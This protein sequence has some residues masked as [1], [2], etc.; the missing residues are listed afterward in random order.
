MSTGGEVFLLEM[1]EPIRIYDLAQQMIRLSG[2]E[3]GKDI[4][5]QV[6]GLRPGEKLYEELLIDQSKAE[7]TKHPRVFS[8]KEHKLSWDILEEKLEKLLFQ[9]QT[10]NYPELINNLKELVTEYQPANQIVTTTHTVSTDRELI[11]K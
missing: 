7:P 5:I 11:E 6:T 8:A 4:E 10:G 1:G 3:P 9:T 2:L